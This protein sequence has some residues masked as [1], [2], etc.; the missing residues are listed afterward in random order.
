MG[1]EWSVGITTA[2]RPVPTLGQTVASLGRAGWLNLSIVRD[3]RGIGAWRNWIGGLRLLIRRQP[4]A[5]AYMI[6]QDDVV[7]C[8]GLRSYLQRSL[9]PAERETVALCSVFTPAAYQTSPPGWHRQCRGW[10]LSAAQAWVIPPESARAIVAELA[11]LDASKHI[12]NHIG[13]WA[14]Q[15]GRV[16]WY[17][18]PSLA[19][20][21]GSGN[22]ALGDDRISDLRRSADFIGEANRP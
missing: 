18:A 7:F 17:H 14:R 15:T 3:T 4:R 19:E 2:P 11:D 21:V 6:C 9:W 16:P 10:Y 22:S 1:F 8:R 5:D 13:K 12:D 20:H